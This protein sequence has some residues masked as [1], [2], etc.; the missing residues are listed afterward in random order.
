MLLRAARELSFGRYRWS[1]GRRQLMS[2]K[3]HRFDIKMETSSPRDRTVAQRRIQSAP[4]P[5]DRIAAYISSIVCQL[6]RLS[7]TRPNS[8]PSSSRVE[9]IGVDRR[10]GR[11]DRSRGERDLTRLSCYHIGIECSTTDLAE[12]PPTA[13]RMVERTSPERESAALFGPLTCCFSGADDEIRTRDPHLGKDM[14]SIRGVT[15]RPLTTIP[16]SGSSTSVRRVVASPALSVQRVRRTTN[17]ART[18]GPAF[19]PGAASNS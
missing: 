8:R 16:S 15:P 19:T 14:R 1:T 2:Y 13:S 3:V 11:D 18:A 12:V 7:V 10:L 4:E 6:N 5:F 9:H 17:S